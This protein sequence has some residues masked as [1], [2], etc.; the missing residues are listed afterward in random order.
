MKTLVFAVLSLA[1]AVA[2]AEGSTIKNSTI[3]V[4]STNKNVVN[5]ATGF[6]GS[7]T[8]NT[9]SVSIKDSTV[10]NSTISNSSTNKNVVN[11]ATGFLGTATANTGSVDIK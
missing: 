4:S 8:A 9:G 3:D 5:T 11:T 7:A 2:F 1:S 10:K 6:L